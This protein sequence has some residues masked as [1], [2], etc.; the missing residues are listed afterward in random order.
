MFYCP[1][2]CCSSKQGCFSTTGLD[3]MTT[4]TTAKQ[5][6]DVRHPPSHLPCSLLRCLLLFLPLGIIIPISHN[7]PSVRL[8]AISSL[9]LHPIGIL[10]LLCLFLPL[11]FR[12]S[13]YQSAQDTYAHDEL[14]PIAFAYSLL[15]GQ[16][17][18]WFP[19]RPPR[20]LH[21]FLRLGLLLGRLVPSC[22]SLSLS[23]PLGRL[24]CCG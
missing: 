24:S 6:V 3:T 2:V 18:A 12:R 11:L 7:L 19:K 13:S 20:S 23:F 17:S 14:T 8:R 22:R 9:R 16:G 5:S 21:R 4:S 15:A 10:L 1:N